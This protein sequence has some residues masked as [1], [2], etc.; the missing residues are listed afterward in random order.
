MGSQFNRH[1][2]FRRRHRISGSDEF[3]AVFGGKLRKTRGVVTV[4]LLANDRA[5]HR[6]GLSVGKR[7][8]NAVVRGR[9]KRMMREAFRHQRAQLPVPSSGGTYDIVV[10]TRK[11]DVLSLEQYSK[12][13]VEAVEAAHR[14]HEKRAG[15]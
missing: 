8:G 13:L 9:L 7:V 6:L 12:M 3:A 2:V 5:E 15:Q 1:L 10:S 4:F 14:A 11:H